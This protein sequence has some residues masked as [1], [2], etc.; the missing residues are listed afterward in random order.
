MH[1]T[2][3]APRIEG[4]LL[5][6]LT[7]PRR[8]YAGLVLLCVLLWSPGFFTLPPGDR[9]ESR[10]AQ[11]TKQMLESGDYVRIMN[12]TEPRNRKPIGIYWL[13]LPFAAAAQA[14]NLARANPVWPYRIPSF[15]GGLLAVCATYGLG[16]LLVG[17]RAA[18]LGSAM[19][20]ASVLLIAETHIAKTDAVLLGATTVALL[21][22]GRAY[23]GPG[24]FTSRQAGFF[25]LAIGAGVLIKG[26]V[27]PM[28]A[29]L[30]TV[31]LVLVDRD[32]RWLRVLR[33]GWGLPLALVLVLPWF[34]AI[35]L[36]TEGR[37]FTDSIGGDL[38]AKL[39]GGDNSHGAP[40]GFYLL[41][42]PLLAF[43][44]SLVLL[45]SL[46]WVWEQRSDRTIRFFLAWIVPAWLVFELIPTKLPN[47]IMPLLPAL[48]LLAGSWV[49]NG[50]WPGPRW[51]AWLSAA[52]YGFAA[53]ALGI[54]AAALPIAVGGK[55]W[56]GLPVLGS[57]VLLAVLVLRRARREAW[58]R[59]SL[60][61][62]AAM[63]LVSGTLLGLELPHLSP[64]WIAPKITAIV[65][66]LHPAALGVAGFNEPSLMFLAGTNTE[67]LLTGGD[68]AR[69]LA[70]APG[71]VVGVSNQQLAAFRDASASLRLAVRPVGQ[72]YGY[73]YSRG[74]R[75]ELTLFRQTKPEA[76]KT[77]PSG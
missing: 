41:L 76:S 2:I 68:A 21:L 37:F 44:G 47:Y 61:G 72:V 1:G 42:L 65:A 28:V 18:L 38:A 13:Q 3:T 77:N 59:A 71:R 63:P 39:A 62:V 14:A 26:P 15:L 51:W 9:D 49:V 66:P 31:A 75:V 19:L 12:G 27:T 56:L 24:P 36:A 70:S 69:F 45:R 60:A 34:V 25:W 29:G 20:A 17:E 55:Q 35:G 10:F 30:A 53:S 54:A 74:R 22:L 43:P 23:C 33:P 58:L 8:A 16:R 67:W 40:P 50:A 48:F 73:N 5:A 4:G 6:R 64:L 32:R 46:P 52:G 11:A 57:A 7:E